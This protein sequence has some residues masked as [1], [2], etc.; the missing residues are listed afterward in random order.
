[1]FSTVLSIGD[2]DWIL[3]F[4]GWRWRLVCVVWVG[5]CIDLSDEFNVMRMGGLK[6]VKL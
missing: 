5:V 2:H 4:G 6:L 3:E 1:M